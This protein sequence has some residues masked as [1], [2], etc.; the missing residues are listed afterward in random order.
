MKPGCFLRKRLAGAAFFISGCLAMQLNSVFPALA[1]PGGQLSPAKTTIRLAQ[2]TSNPN[3]VKSLDGKT[4]DIDE[5]R[6]LFEEHQKELERVE[7]EKQGLQSET[8]TLTDESAKLQARLIDAAKNVQ[9]AEKK[10]TRSEGEIAELSKQEAKIRIALSESQAKITQ[11]LAVMQRMGREPPPV[12]M[13]ERNDALRMVRSAMILAS[14]FPGF[15]E[16]ADQLSETLSD[17]NT[18][19]A[20]S[21]EEHKRLAAA[22]TDFTRLKSEIG[23]LLAQ[24]Q[25][26][27]Q[28]N[29]DQ[30]EKLKLAASRHSRAV[31]DFGGLLKR[32]D[33]EVAQGSNLASYEAELKRLGPAVELKPAVKQAAF[34]SPGRMKPALPFEKTKG[35][36]PFPAQGTRLKSFGFK[37]D[38]GGKS[39]GIYV[40][41]RRSAQITSPSDGWVIYAGQFRSYGRLLIINAGGGYHI[42]LAGLDQIYTNVGQFVLAG[43]P[44]AAMGNSAQ[45]AEG[46]VQ[47]RNPVLYIEFR[48]DARPVDPDP[49]WSEGV[50][51]G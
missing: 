49:W 15:K 23:D 27:M 38:V 21:R 19:I 7:S 48:K 51:E 6:R 43:E 1:E 17:L 10:L 31:T 22:E 8:Q 28:K 35:L 14:F 24:K 37:D 29:W 26:K 30:I 2:N 3:S 20:K 50:K 33:S 32:L 9:E 5:A 25:D 16:Q 34:V 4:I 18:I 36:L 46:S 42:L 12:M 44:V 11:M 13:T 40:E 45:L 41:T 39:E 47:S